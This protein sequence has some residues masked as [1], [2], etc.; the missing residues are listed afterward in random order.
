[1]S[2]TRPL[3]RCPHCRGSQCRTSAYDISRQNPS[4]AKCIFCKSAMVQPVPF[5]A[6]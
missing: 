6:C 4:G 1:M 2:T 5:P 3:L